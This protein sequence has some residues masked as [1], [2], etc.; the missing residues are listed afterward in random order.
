MNHKIKIT[1]ESNAGC[2]V[3]ETDQQVLIVAALSKEEGTETV[4]TQTV[5]ACCQEANLSSTAVLGCM[6]MERIIQE[7]NECTSDEAFVTLMQ[8][9]ADKSAKTILFALAERYR[10]TGGK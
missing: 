5:F 4:K 10:E 1:V 9:L 6:A 2:R 3:I 7:I 8:Y